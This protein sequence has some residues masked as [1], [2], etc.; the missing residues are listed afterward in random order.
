MKELKKTSGDA[1]FEVPAVLAWIGGGNRTFSRQSWQ[2]FSDL[3]CLGQLVSV[4]DKQTLTKSIC[5]TSH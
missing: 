3:E 2:I 1:I 5:K 4:E